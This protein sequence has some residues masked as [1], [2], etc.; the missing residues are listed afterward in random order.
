M[1]A[2]DKSLEIVLKGKT[3]T[4]AVTFN[5]FS[6]VHNLTAGPVMTRE[7]HST[8]VLSA[9][10]T[11]GA[12]VL[13]VQ[14]IRTASKSSAASSLLSVNL[15]S[16]T[17]GDTPVWTAESE[18]MVNS[19]SK[20]TQLKRDYVIANCCKADCA[21]FIVTFT[22]VE[23]SPTMR[24]ELKRARL[25]ADW[26]PNKVVAWLLTLPSCWIPPTLT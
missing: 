25:D 11:E 12:S 21:T 6:L 16:S 7:D 18:G 13:Y 2:V 4:F 19:F 15:Q 24:R 3:T 10:F 22:E 23:A 14:L 5:G 20:S 1:Q 9:G 26:Q 8:W 17:H